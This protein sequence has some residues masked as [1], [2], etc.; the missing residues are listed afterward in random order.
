[1]S[2]FFV[3]LVLKTVI[4]IP[5]LFVSSQ[6]KRAYYMLKKRLQIVCEDTNE[7]N[8]VFKTSHV[9]PVE[10]A[11]ANIQQGLKLEHYESDTYFI[12]RL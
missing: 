11:N 6:T 3:M 12:D 10:F 5:P 1:M 7:S 8:E 9:Y 2:D 4:Y